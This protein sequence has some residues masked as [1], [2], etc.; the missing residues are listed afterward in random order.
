[1]W[2]QHCLIYPGALRKVLRLLAIR[3][4]LNVVYINFRCA[5]Y[6]QDWPAA[7]VGGYAGS[8]EHLGNERLQDRDV[9]RWEELISSRSATCTQSYAHII[10]RS[11]W[12]EFWTGR[13]IGSD[14]TGVLTTY[15]H[16][17]TVAETE[18]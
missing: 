8:Y 9:A 14:F 16:T 2:S 1:M 6:P 17:C 5:N 11:V 15:P 10:K 3:R 18:F 7:A 12:R 13:D 4:R